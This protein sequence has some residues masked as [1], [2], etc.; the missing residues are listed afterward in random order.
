MTALLR[1]TKITMITR[2]AWLTSAMHALGA[3]FFPAVLPEGRSET[4]TWELPKKLACSCGFPWN[5]KEAIGQCFSPRATPDGTTHMFVCPTQDEPVRVLDIL[6]HELGHAALG[7]DEGHGPRFRRF[8]K[9]VGLSGKA[10]ATVAEPGTELHERLTRIARDLGPYPHKAL[11]K[12]GGK[13][14]EK[15]EKKNGWIR[16]VSQTDPEYKV[17]ISAKQLEEKGPP[18]DYCGLE[19][20]P[21]S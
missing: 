12:G 9:L 13:K 17:V 20:E 6:L 16:M 8:V 7:V 1:D 5:H 14:K 3:H 2:E 15:G 4:R 11:S 18:Q 10:T 19:M 21:V